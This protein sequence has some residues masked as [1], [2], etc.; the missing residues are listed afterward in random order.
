MDS[1]S[2][3]G[4]A[5]LHALCWQLGMGGQAMVIFLYWLLTLTRGP[6]AIFLNENLLS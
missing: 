4:L 6:I 3:R 2:L 1:H 5:N